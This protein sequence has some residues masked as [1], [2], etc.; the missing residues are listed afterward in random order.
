MI[1]SQTETASTL[2]VCPDSEIETFLCS[3]CKAPFTPTNRRQRFCGPN[4]RLNAHREPQRA[5]R[6]RWDG[7]RSFY[8][9][10]EFDGRQVGPM[11]NV[12]PL[13][14]FEKERRT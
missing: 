2:P 9:T 7:A 1:E 13:A 10:M 12:G 3:H 5:K 8:R 14:E 4:C 6:R 11:R